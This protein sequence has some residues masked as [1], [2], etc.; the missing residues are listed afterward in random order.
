[1]KALNFLKRF[2]IAALPI[3]AFFVLWQ[4]GSSHVPRGVISSPE[5]I[6]KAMWKAFIDPEHVLLWHTGQSLSRILRGYL[7]ASVV[8]ITLGFALGTYFR[9]L[10]KLFLPFFRVC[11][12][13]NPFAIIPVFMILFG[14]G[15]KEK[16]AV[17]FWAAFW[18]IFFN[19]QEGAKSVDLAL[20]RSARSMGANRFKVFTGVIFPYTLPS[21]FTGLRLSSRVAF[22]MMVA[23]ETL[24]AINGLGWY[25]AQQRIVHKLSLIYGSIL[26]ITVLAILVN[27]LFVRLEKHFLVW[28]EAALK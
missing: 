8:G 1:M 10:E 20:V 7:L 19:T 12:K 5:K 14:V 21:I 23:S 17:V 25:Y 2:L 24:G 26:F 4:I 15:D 18:P 6:A 27:F 16:I 9:S 28:K 3:I 11:E 22:F 13:L